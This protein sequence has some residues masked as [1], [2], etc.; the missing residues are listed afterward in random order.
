MTLH[1]RPRGRKQHRQPTVGRHPH[2]AAR[3]RDRRSARIMRA[4]KP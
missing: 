1:G 4:V 2:A 3:K